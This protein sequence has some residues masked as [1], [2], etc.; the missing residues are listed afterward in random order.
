MFVA[1]WCHQTRFDETARGWQKFGQRS[2]GGGFHV[3]SQM[4]FLCPSN[5]RFTQIP[6]AHGAGT[7]LW[8][9]SWLAF[10]AINFE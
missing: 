10:I 8:S 9:I 5:A 1:V 6:S 3:P 2:M 4:F 7:K